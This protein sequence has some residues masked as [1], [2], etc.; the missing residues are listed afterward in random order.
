M[1]LKYLFLSSCTFRSPI[2]SVHCTNV[3]GSIAI[4][5]HYHIYIY[6][7]FFFFLGKQYYR[8]AFNFLTA[9]HDRRDARQSPP[10]IS[11]TRQ[12][13]ILARRRIERARAEPASECDIIWRRR[14]RSSSPRR[15]ST[16]TCSR[17]EAHV[18]SISTLSREL[19]DGDNA[20]DTTSRFRGCSRQQGPR[21]LFS[22]C[23]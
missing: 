5:H 18:R 10:V 21:I 13:R 16:V 7:S 15:D 6:I 22:S 2:C 14:R 23:S 4:Y 19:P 11:T 8:T 3:N 1:I 17:S 9:A 20:R 12:F